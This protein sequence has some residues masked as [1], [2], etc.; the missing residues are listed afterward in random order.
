MYWMCVAD[1][2]K[3]VSFKK[4]QWVSVRIS[5]QAIFRAGFGGGA[6]NTG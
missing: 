2:E 5:Y 6:S 3:A 1:G 4:E